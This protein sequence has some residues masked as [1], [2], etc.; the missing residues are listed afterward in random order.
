[1]PTTLVGCKSCK[2]Q[3]KFMA[4]FLHALEF[5]LQQYFRNLLTQ[6]EFPN[7]LPYLANAYIAKYPSYKYSN[8][9]LFVM[10]SAVMF[11]KRLSARLSSVHASRTPLR[12]R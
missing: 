8:R 1:M 6:E 3:L 2:P 5:N 4:L 11:P 12:Y 10:K 7:S 9:W